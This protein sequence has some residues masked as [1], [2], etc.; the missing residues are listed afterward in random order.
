[1]IDNYPY[2]DVVWHPYLEE[3]DEGQP[4][5]VQARPYFGRSVW[6]HTLNLVL[7]LNLFLCQRSLGLRQSAVEF[8]TRDPFRKPGR[9]FRGLHNTTDWRVRAQEQ[10]NNWEHRGKAVKSAATTD[11]AY[12]QAYALKYGGKVYKSAR[13]QVDVAGEIASL[14][15]LLCSATQDREVAQKQVEELRRELDRVRSAA[16]GGD[17][18]S[19]GEERHQRELTDQLAAAVLRAEEAEMD[20]ADRVRELRTATD[21]ALELQGQMDSVQSERGRLQGEM[22]TVRGE[23]DQLCIR[24]E[25]AEARAEEA[26]RELEALRLRGPS[27]CQEEIAHATLRATDSVVPGV[28]VER[29][30]AGTLVPPWDITLRV[31]PADGG[32]RRRRGA[33]GVRRV[34]RVL[35]VVEACYHHW[36]GRRDQGR[37]VVVSEELVS[38]LPFIY[39]H[40]GCKDISYRLGQRR[41]L[42]SFGSIGLPGGIAI[43]RW[44]DL[45]VLALIL[46]RVLPLRRWLPIV[47][48]VPRLLGLLGIWRPT[49][50]A[51]G[52]ANGTYLFVDLDPLGDWALQLLGITGLGGLKHGMY[53][54]VLQ[55]GLNETGSAI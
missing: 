19:R 24:A 2:L 27:V 5:L 49:Y 8:P 9:S 34:P 44:R 29:V 51:L 46:G 28:G 4:Q 48:V 50:W 21:R 31:P 3:G 38:H 7:P 15:A 22:E 36:I 54:R 45:G 30:L 39:G 26:T 14:R 18:S 35:E 16:A 32:T 41:V 53:R 40:E 33:A 52:I 37:V 1:M 17:S 42:G 25:A 13:H 55:L 43:L 20:L 11:D 10:I 12:L 47:V 23:R 6:L